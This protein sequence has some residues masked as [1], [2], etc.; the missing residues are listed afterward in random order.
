MRTISKVLVVIGVF[1]ILI[2]IIGRVY[3]E[4]KQEALYKAYVQNIEMDTNP[5]VKQPVVSNE[6]E[7]E[8]EASHEEPAVINS[9]DVIG[10]IR[11]SKIDLDLIILEGASDYEL[12]LGAGHIQETAQPGQIGNCVIAGHRNYTFGSMFNRLGEVE[13]EDEVEIEFMGQEYTYKVEDI[14]IVTPDD[15]SVLGQNATDKLLTLITCHPI[16]TGTHRLIITGRLE[17]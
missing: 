1:L 5:I 3:T 16:Y 11:M 8:V 10:K 14:K 2:P 7:Q 9:G 4:Y 17:E 13:L 12:G 15:L 6:V